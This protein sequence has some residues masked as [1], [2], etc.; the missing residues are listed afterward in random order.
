MARACGALLALVAV[1][2]VQAQLLGEVM[3]V[4]AVS[5]ELNPAVR[6]PSGSYRV[7]GNP[8]PALLARVEG[9]QQFGSWEA[10]MARGLAANLQAGFV[11]QL[12]T[13]FAVAGYFLESQSETSVGVET[14]QRYFFVGDDGGRVLLYLIRT[15][16]EL[17]WLIGKAP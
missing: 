9:A 3:T 7:V 12:A 8:P 15:P 1:G 5:A 17:V 14:H 2:G 10:Y 6:F 4:V 11:Q 16:Q 13:S